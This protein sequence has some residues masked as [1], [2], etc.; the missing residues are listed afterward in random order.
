[1]QPATRRRWVEDEDARLRAAVETHGAA[2]WGEIARVLGGERSA[3]KCR[4][5]WFYHLSPDVHKR[6][7][8]PGEDAL[9]GAASPLGRW[10][11]AVAKQLHGRSA[12]AVRNRAAL[13]RSKAARE[14][15]EPLDDSLDGK[16]ARARRAAR[17]R[18]RLRV[19]AARACHLPHSWR[20]QLLRREQ[21]QLHRPATRAPLAA[22]RRPLG[23]VA[24]AAG[25]AA[26]RAHVPARALVRFVRV[27]DDDDALRAAAPA[28]VA[29]ARTSRNNCGYGGQD[30]NHSGR[31]WS[32]RRD[33]GWELR[34]V[35]RG[36]RRCNPR[37][38]PRR[39]RR[40]SGV[41]AT[42]SALLHLECS[43]RVV[44]WVGWTE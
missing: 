25:H 23:H 34:C 42:L 30:P 40:R 3:S 35:D 29:R 6:D 11:A 18:P 21:L 37:A 16:Y 26:D 27:D 10:A 8:L 33:S 7:W 12:H 9:I 20:R 19:R 38:R 36:H 5:R 17:S 1:M 39:S 32:R 44:L 28:D 24:R 31:S 13:L 41:A 2:Q 43:V 15:G 22:P 4:E 14:C